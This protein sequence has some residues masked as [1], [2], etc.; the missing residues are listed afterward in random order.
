MGC[1]GRNFSILCPGVHIEG[2]GNWVLQFFYSLFLEL[3]IA[4]L[5][6][7]RMWSAIG[8]EQVHIESDN[9]QMD[10]MGSYCSCNYYMTEFQGSGEWTRAYCAR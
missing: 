8:A 1:I 2:G 7:I 3:S 9:Q 6:F 10:E 5:G 4:L